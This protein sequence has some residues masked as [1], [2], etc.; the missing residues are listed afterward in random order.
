MPGAGVLRDGAH[1]DAHAF[2]DGEFLDDLAEALALLGILDLAGNPE[3][4]CKGH[5]DE[6]TAS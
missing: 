3:L 1:D 6:V 5:E 2:R 4:F